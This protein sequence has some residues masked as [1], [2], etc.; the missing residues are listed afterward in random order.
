MISDVL[1]QCEQLIGYE[2]SDKLLLEVCLTHASGARSRLESNERLEFLGDSILGAVVCD[3]LYRQFPEATEGELTR[4]KSEVV[5]RAT[6]AIL[7]REIGLHQVIKLGKGIDRDRDLPD[8]ILAGVFEAI[9]AG[10]YYDSDYQTAQKFVARLTDDYVRRIMEN[11][12]E[13]NSKSI[14]QQ[15]SQKRF[16]ETPIY[17]LLEERG[18][19]HS[20]NFQVS[21]MIGRRQFPPAWGTNKKEAEQ[22]A[23]ANA[24]LEIEADPLLS[25][26]EGTSSDLELDASQTTP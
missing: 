13:K 16:G 26:T 20:K 9:I 24:L 17:A 1:A 6:C 22:R 8:S 4:I 5:S 12:G 11:Q 21:A 15:L 14:L 2:F 18:P 23:A 7:A 3:Q 10:I 25:P 19:D